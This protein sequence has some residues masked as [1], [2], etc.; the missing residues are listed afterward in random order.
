MLNEPCRTHFSEQLVIKLAKIFDEARRAQALHVSKQ[1][2]IFPNSQW[3]VITVFALVGLPFFLLCAYFLALGVTISWQN[4]LTTIGRHSS[5]DVFRS[6]SPFL[7]F[8]L[9][10][11]RCVVSV[12]FATGPFIFIND[13]IR[14]VGKQ[15]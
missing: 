4:G 5:I 2:P 11:M 7:F 14:N 9:I 10:A 3:I 8:I 6:E 1:K 13:A 12:L 15:R